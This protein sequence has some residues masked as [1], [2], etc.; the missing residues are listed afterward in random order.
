MIRLHAEVL[1]GE[2]VALLRQHPQH[3]GFAERA[4]HRGYPDVHLLARDPDRDASVLGQ[5]ALRDVDAR[6]EL[7]PRRHRGKALDGLRQLRVQDAVDAHPHREVLFTRLHV[8]VG[9][10]QVHRLREQVVHKLDDGRL[11]RHLSKVSGAVA[12]IQVL[13]RTLFPDEV[14]QAVDLMIGGQAER[15]EPARIEVIEGFEQCMVQN[16]AGDA[17]ELLVLTPHQ[18]RVVEE[19]LQLDRRLRDEL[20]HV[21]AVRQIFGVSEIDG[22]LLLGEPL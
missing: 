13:D 16:V 8:D 19:P 3:D 2:L 9:R 20:V 22:A 6:D 12:R 18:H 7:D 1:Q 21:Q 10:P 11:F 4:R 14:Q 17:E 5:P 15:H